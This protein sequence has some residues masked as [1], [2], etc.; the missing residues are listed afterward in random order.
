[1]SR[2]TSEYPERVYASS[3]EQKKHGLMERMRS[4]DKSGLWLIGGLAAIGLGFWAAY[5]FGP[6]LV[7]YIKMERM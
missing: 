7:R 3:T 1:M 4:T 2:I 5:K 6:D